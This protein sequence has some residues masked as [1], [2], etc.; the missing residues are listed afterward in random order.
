MDIRPLDLHHDGWIELE[1]RVWQMKRKPSEQKVVERRSKDRI[2]AWSYP[3]SGG[4][5][6][7]CY[8]RV[9]GRMAGYTRIMVKEGYGKE[10]G[11]EVALDIPPE[12][13]I[14]LVQEAVENL[15][16]AK[17]KAEQNL[18][19]MKARADKLAYIASKLAD[20]LSKKGESVR[21]ADFGIEDDDFRVEYEHE[22]EDLADRLVADETVECS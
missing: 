22:F 7:L 14:Y 3:R 15:I 2:T 16:D 18:E 10:R 6:T 5:S 12:P 8:A 17:M 21:H 11:V 1:T 20:R 13:L 9:L 4:D 19:Y